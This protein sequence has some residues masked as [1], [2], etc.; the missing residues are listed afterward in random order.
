MFHFQL[1]IQ[2]DYR[3]HV[4]RKVSEYKKIFFNTNASSIFFPIQWHNPDSKDMTIW[5]LDFH[6]SQ[7]LP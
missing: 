6:L 4:L 3:R 7:K 1:V 5:N 2:M